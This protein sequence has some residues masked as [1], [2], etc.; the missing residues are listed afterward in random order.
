MV[1]FRTKVLS[2]EISQ[3]VYDKKMK[4]G[5]AE[6]CTGGRVAESLIAVPGSS[7]YFEGGVIAYSEDLKKNI[8][9]VDA[10]VIEEQTCVCE[11]VARQMVTGTIK[12][13]GVDIAVATTGTA[14][15]S[16]GTPEV[17]VGTIWIA[18]GTKDDIRTTKLTEDFGRD[19]NLAIAT[20]TALQMLLDFLRERFP[21]PED[22]A[23]ELT[24]E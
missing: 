17:P 6:S 7:N 20:N 2:R 10:Q 3:A 9:G 22:D 12:H 13:L 14:G 19:T 24:A 4:I 15:P 11:E 1:E 18:V 16:G 21:E 8:L 5:T 23:V